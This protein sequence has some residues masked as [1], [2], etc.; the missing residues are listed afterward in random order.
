MK[1][2]LIRIYSVA[3][4]LASLLYVVYMTRM[5]ILAECVEWSDSGNSDYQKYLGSSFEN[6][7]WGIVI[8]CAFL[9]F[10]FALPWLKYYK[11]LWCG[12][13]YR[14]WLFDVKSV[15]AK[16]ACS[17]YVLF[18]LFLVFILFKL[19]QMPELDGNEIA[20]RDYTYEIFSLVLLSPVYLIATMAISMKLEKI[21]K[22][23]SYDK[24]ED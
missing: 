16:I 10:S 4:I 18:N 6:I 9:S 5:I 22:F 21:N 3:G 11:D 13:E 12:C 8:I 15:R 19:F 2:V 7:D 17:I 14:F 1:K 23:N 20:Y 24:S